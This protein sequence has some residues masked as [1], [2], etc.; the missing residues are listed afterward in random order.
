MQTNHDSMCREFQIKFMLFIALM[1]VRMVTALHQKTKTW[2]FL[3][4]ICVLLKL[5][6]YSHKSF[7]FFGEHCDNQ[8][9]HYIR[10]YRENENLALINSGARF[11]I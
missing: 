6:I 11:S 1:K 8:I 3:V 2:P 4:R 10:G 7:T 5:H 9:T